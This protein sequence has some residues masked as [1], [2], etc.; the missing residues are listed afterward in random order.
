MTTILI[1]DDEAVALRILQHT[2]NKQGYSVQTASNGNEALRLAKK[3]AFELMI[4]DISMPMMDGV[5]LLQELR[6]LPNTAKIPII[7]LTASSQD[8]DRVRAENAGAS[9]YITKPFSSNQIVEAVESL[10]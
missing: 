9:L 10:L 7:M 4:L 1:V 8:E 2:L 3:S 6:Q 5:E